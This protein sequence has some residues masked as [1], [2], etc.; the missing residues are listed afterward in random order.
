MSTFLLQRSFVYS[1]PVTRN[2]PRRF[3]TSSSV[4]K[5][6]R[7]F[8][9]I[10]AL[11]AAA[12]TAY[13]VGSVYPPSAATL[14]FPRAAPAPIDPASPAGIAYTTSLEETLQS[15]PL[16]ESLRA[17][18]DAA[19]WY[20]VRPY[21]A[22]PEARRVNSLTGGALRGPGKLAL[23]PLARVKRDESESYVFIH[24]GRGLCGHD[25]IVHGGL[26]ATLLDETLARTVGPGYMC[27]VAAC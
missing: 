6:R 22:L 16:I 2:A 25:G 8:T 1:R 23:H 7:P 19:D 12:A 21:K 24:L 10:A 17:Q 26:L 5:S 18:P 14:L 20:E 3:L 4:P 27:L 13:A 11:G 15:L 9:T